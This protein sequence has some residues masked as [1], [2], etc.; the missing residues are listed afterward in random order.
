MTQ[1]FPGFL[2]CS[3]FNPAL[4]I[5]DNHFNKHL[6][7]CWDLAASPQDRLAWGASLEEK[8]EGGGGEEERQRGRREKR[9]RENRIPQDSFSLFFSQAKSVS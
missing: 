8:G 4:L 2:Q 5:S 6:N 7:L 1:H 9:R 3:Q